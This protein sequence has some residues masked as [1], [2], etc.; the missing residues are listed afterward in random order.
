MLT[1]ADV[2]SLECYA[3]ALL[4]RL[5]CIGDP[6]ENLGEAVSAYR[7]AHKYDPYKEDSALA[8]IADADPYQEGEGDL[9]ALMSGLPDE[10]M[11]GDA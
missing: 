9:D 2:S 7:K 10:E 3:L 1:I 5:H 8:R 6:V 4:W 11:P